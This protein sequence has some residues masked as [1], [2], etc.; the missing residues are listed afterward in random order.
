MSEEQIKQI[1]ERIF[2]SHKSFASSIV[3]GVDINSIL[4]LLQ[5]F[6]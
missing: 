5:R 1:E 3:F 4:F 2:K 6:K